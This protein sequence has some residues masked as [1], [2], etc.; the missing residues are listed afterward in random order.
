MTVTG[1]ETVRAGWLA[2]S[3]KNHH[4]QFA[5]M[6]APPLVVS[7]VRTLNAVAAS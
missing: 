4:S 2:G 3:L 1:Y 7:E 5:A 6:E